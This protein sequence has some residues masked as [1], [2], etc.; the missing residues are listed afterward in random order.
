[1]AT[2]NAIDTPLRTGGLAPDFEQIYRQAGGDRTQIRWDDGRPNPLLVSWLDRS[3]SDELRPGS[4]VAVVGC[5]LG[6]D[7]RELARRGYDVTAFDLSPTAI[8]WAKSIDPEWASIFCV[9]DLL[10]LPSRW[11]HRFD[12]V[13]EIYTI[14]SMPPE[15]RPTTMA[16]VASLLH[17]HGRLLV[18]CR[19]ADRPQRGDDGPPW[20]LTVDE[21]RELARAH[22][23]ECPSG[24][25]LSEDGETPP[26]PRIRAYLR[27]PVE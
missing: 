5:G 18:V 11:R 16:A 13:V 25:E 9:A 15:T 6:Y 3:A 14:Q 4:R 21:L 22:D 27:R 7:A 20:A 19:G 17:P 26:K 8:E 12:L 23:L 2:S 1:M 10:A 24:F